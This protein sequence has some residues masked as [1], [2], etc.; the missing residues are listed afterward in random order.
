MGA[1]APP[2]CWTQP[3]AVRAAAI[4]TTL[5]SGCPALT[6]PS[7]ASGRG[8]RRWPVLA[9]RADQGELRALGVAALDDPGAAGDFLRAVVHL[10][11][12]LLHPA[13]GEVD[14]GDDEVEQPV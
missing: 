9:L 12:R 8:F 11:A 5:R 2:G 13:Q 3:C 6:L 14:A 1:R 4:R 10:A 7:H